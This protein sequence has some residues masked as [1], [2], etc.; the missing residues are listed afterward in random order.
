MTSHR[1]YRPALGIDV[2]IDE[3]VSKKGVA[4]DQDV[5]AAC[6][7]VMRKQNNEFD[8]SY[9]EISFIDGDRIKDALSGSN[10]IR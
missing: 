1:P 2:A 8:S 5:V 4:Y 9:V 6:L 3:I 7:S 10:E